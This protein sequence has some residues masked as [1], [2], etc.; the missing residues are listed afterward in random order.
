MGHFLSTNQKNKLTL[1]NQQTMKTTFLLTTAIA[2]LLTIQVN[3]GIKAE[4]AKTIPPV[5]R[6][7]APKIP[8]V[9]NF[10]EKLITTGKKLINILDLAPEVPSSA[11]F[12][13]SEINSNAIAAE[14]PIESE[15]ELISTINESFK[16]TTNQIACQ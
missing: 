12:N 10:E 7:L 16:D 11:E 14:V 9:A 2:T 5:Y 15:K 8:I 3:A 4:T 1:K 13:D 6:H